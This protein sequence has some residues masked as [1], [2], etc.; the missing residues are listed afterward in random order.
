MP[1]IPGLDGLPVLVEPSTRELVA[2]ARCFGFGGPVEFSLGGNRSE[3]TKLS[4]VG[5][6]HP[7]AWSEP[8]YLRA[9]VP[10][11]WHELSVGGLSAIGHLS[12]FV[13]YSR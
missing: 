7:G 10:S 2:R 6:T 1:V 13:L 11:G 9:A 12:G 4:G 5:L 3:R 8:I